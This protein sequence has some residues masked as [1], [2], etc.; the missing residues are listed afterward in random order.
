MLPQCHLYLADSG[1]RKM[2]ALALLPGKC[3]S[4]DYRTSAITAKKHYG[5]IGLRE[6][7]GGFDTSAWQ[8]VFKYTFYYIFVPYLPAVNMADSPALIQDGTRHKSERP[9]IG[10]VFNP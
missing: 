8:K 6:R 10:T 3:D 7:P 9:V 2:P 5:I 4:R 1:L